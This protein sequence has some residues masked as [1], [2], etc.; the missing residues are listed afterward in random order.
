MLFCSFTAEAVVI[1]IHGSFAA[2]RGWWSTSGEFFKA[3]EKEAARLGERVVPFCWSGHPS[4]KLIDVAGHNLAWLI[5]SYPRN[6]HITVIAH[7]NGGN[8][9]NAASRALFDPI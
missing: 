5:L 3:V 7:S 1:V 6:E 4:A 9:V 2:D 8:V